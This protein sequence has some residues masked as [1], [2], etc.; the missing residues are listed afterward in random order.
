MRMDGRTGVGRSK[1][2][3]RI[4]SCGGLVGGNAKLEPQ[5]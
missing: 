4:S 2:K 5:I 3:G 1:R